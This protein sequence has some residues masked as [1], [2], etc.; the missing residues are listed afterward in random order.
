MFLTGEPISANKALLWGLV[1]DVVP[2]KEL[3]KAVDALC[4]KLIDRFPESTRY[5]REQV[6]F[7]KDLA[8]EAM[9]KEA[10]EW[11]VAHFLGEEPLE[12]M[13]S[14]GDKRE[15]DYRAFRTKAGMARE[16]RPTTSEIVVNTIDQEVRS[17]SRSCYSCGAEDIPSSF[18]YCGVCGTR[19]V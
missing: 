2:Y 9:I 6:S 5:A 11:L 3:D 7:W 17:T 14:L 4:L 19:L 16:V 1:N 18:S 15:I 10:N 13:T 12:G 8:W